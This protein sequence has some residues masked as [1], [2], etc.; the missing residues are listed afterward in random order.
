M[1]FETVIFDLDGTLLDSLRG[2]ASAMN[3]LLERLGYPVQTLEAYKYF[4]GDGITELVTRALPEDKRAGH[5]ID[6]LVREYREIYHTTWPEQSPPYNGIPQLLDTLSKEK[7]KLAV[8]SNKSDDFTKRMVT[9]LLPDW[10]F[11][12]VFGVRPGVPRKPDPTAALEIVEMLGATPEKTIFMGDSGIDMETATRANMTAVGV[13][14]GFREKE[15]LSA[16]GADHLIS[17]P[18]ELLKIMKK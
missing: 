6:E 17:H 9:A 18:S 8:L 4:V 16:D 2:I 7:I 13:L 14:W 12:V 11:E 1:T 5:D 15:E 10:N 3:A